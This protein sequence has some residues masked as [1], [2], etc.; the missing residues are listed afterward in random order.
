MASIPGINAVDAGIDVDVSH[1]DIE[2]F[3]NYLVPAVWWN[4][5]SGDWSTLTNWNSGQPASVPVTPADQAPPY[6]YTAGA[7][8]T[9]RLLGASGSGPTSGQYDTVILERP[10]ANITVTLSTGTHN[11]RKLYMRET[12]NITG[13]SLTVNYDPTYRA[14]DSADVLHGGPIS[15]Q[16]SGPVTLA[17]SGSLT[18]HTLQV[19]TTRTFTLAGGTLTFNTINL[20]TH[21]T[22]PAKIVLNS[23]VN[24]NPLSN[25][26]TAVVAKGSGS[27]ISGYIDL[28]G[29]ARAFTVANGTA[30]IDLSINVPM[31]NSGLTKSG[32]GTMQVVS[33][34]TYTGGTIVSAGRLLVNN[35][36]GS[37]TGSGAVTV[38]GGFLGGTGII[39]GA[40]T[41]NSGGTIQPGTASAMG[42]LTIGNST[43]F[44]GTNLMRIDRNGG[45]S[46]ADKIAL[47][48]GTLNYGGTLV[49]SN[50]GA[51]LTGGEVFTNFS[52]TTYTGAF[53]ASNL[54]TLG[55][56]LNWYLGGLTNNGTIKVNRK[57]VASNPSTFTN[58]APTVLQIPITSLTSIVTDP[59][60]DSISLAGMTMTT[61]N[62]ITLTT[63]GAFITYSNRTSVSDKFTYT[64]SDGHGGSSTGTVSIVNIG[65]APTAQ[66][67][68]APSWNGSSMQL[69]FAAV[70]G[71]TYYLE[72]STN[73]PDWSTI[74]TNIAA[75]SGVFDYTD[76]FHDLNP[77]AAAAFY[78]LRWLP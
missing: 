33:N 44:G 29:A 68:G 70:P 64:V 55:A 71:W 74:W 72:R 21:S 57:P 77:P 51:A 78:R 28:G 41:V 53:T 34:N 24:L 17:N 5:T 1:G 45:V 23:D 49:V 2:Y 15:A 11:I 63:N 60:S 25:N 31:S 37:G 73:L 26:I 50:A 59:D 46:L 19:D 56:G 76:D 65:S 66:F 40:V 38:N 9:A 7:M 36:T 69:H 22:T 10:S 39:S 20:M 58:T 48:S 35:T 61:T 8:P 67:T 18:V 12:L 52:A 13:G 42:K 4:N 43:T 30:E 75:P 3:R 32:A 62:G 54:P 27:G 16:F 14:N 47:S 6:T